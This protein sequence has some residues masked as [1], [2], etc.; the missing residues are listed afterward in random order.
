MRRWAAAGLVAVALAGCAHERKLRLN[1]DHV[2]GADDY[3]EI[4]QAWT[5][6]DEVYHDLDSVLFA[7]ATF[8]SSEVRRAFG[9][10][11]PVMYGPGSEE[12]SRLLLTGPDAELHH[13]F[14]FSGATHLPEWNDFD[15]PDSIWRITLQA[16]DREPVE[17]QVER[18]KTNANLRVIYPYITDYAKTYRLRFPLTTP[19]GDP[20]LTPRTRV[21]HLTITSALGTAHMAWVLTPS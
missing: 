13:E 11:H 3:E 2:L 17:A 9:L 10:R 19:E 18:I 5:R 12:A 16:D 20:V 7:H 15:K 21:M 4:L 1:S 6:S 14:F 8:H